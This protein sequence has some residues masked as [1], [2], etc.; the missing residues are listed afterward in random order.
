LHETEIKKNITG[1]REKNKLMTAYQ[2]EAENLF[3]ERFGNGLYRLEF[4]LNIKNWSVECIVLLVR[5]LSNRVCGGWPIDWQLRQLTEL[6]RV[7]TN[8]IGAFFS[9]SKE[10]CKV[11]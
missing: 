4:Q 7:S 10:L 6:A 5:E 9:N 1:Y 3:E 8:S 2:E 11:W